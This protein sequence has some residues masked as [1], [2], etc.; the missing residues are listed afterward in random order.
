MLGQGNNCRRCR[1]IT[2]GRRA[3]RVPRI[4]EE[5]RENIEQAIH[6]A[7]PESSQAWL[8]EIPL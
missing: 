2:R 7:I 6:G 8:T 4:D 1:Q 5:P 3:S